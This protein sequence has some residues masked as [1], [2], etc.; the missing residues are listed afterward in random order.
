MLDVRFEAE[1]CATSWSKYTSSEAQRKPLRQIEMHNPRTAQT[2]I[3]LILTELKLHL[4]T[5]WFC[6]IYYLTKYCFFHP[7]INYC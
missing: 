5:L 3:G 2:S 4:A 6:D 1:T 7:R